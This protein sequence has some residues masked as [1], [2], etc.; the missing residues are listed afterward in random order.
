MLSRIFRMKRKTKIGMLVLSGVL[1]VS[2]WVG[3]GQSAG[4]KEYNDFDYEEINGNIIINSYNGDKTQLVPADFPKEGNKVITIRANAFANST[5]REIA[6]PTSVTTIE[7]GAFFN[8][9]NLQLIS[10]SGCNGLTTISDNTFA[11]CESLINISLPENVTSIGQGAFKDCKSLTVF[12]LRENMDYI[13]QDAF[14]GCDSLMAFD[15]SIKKA[16]EEVTEAA[17]TVSEETGIEEESPTTVSKS[18]GAETYK[19]MLYDTYIYGGQSMLKLTNVPAGLGKSSL[20]AADFHPNCVA[21]GQ[22]AFSGNTEITNVVLPSTIRAIERDAFSDSTVVSITIPSS[23]STIEAQT[24]WYV[25]QEVYGAAGSVAE[26]F[27][28]SHGTQMGINVQFSVTQGGESNN[29]N[30]NNTPVPDTNNNNNNNN[31]NSGVDTNTNTNANGTP[32]ININ[33]TNNNS[34]TG[35]ASQSTSGGK[36]AT[37]KTADGDID[38]RWF[39]IIG[40]FLA[41]VAVI[42]FS[43]FRKFQYVQNNKKN[44]DLDS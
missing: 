24:N 29:N 25:L 19:G 22:R 6:I 14:D 12:T 28:N 18:Y 27:A 5:I 42:S 30:N 38:P 32:N 16:S 9:K 7:N 34:V 13:A 43:R 36:D 37:P 31:T 41:G 3:V 35:G 33:N 1:L 11:G 21:I 20:S 8:C 44:S 23:V 2:L 40:V 10:I 4:A 17:S 15:T 39:L 26:T